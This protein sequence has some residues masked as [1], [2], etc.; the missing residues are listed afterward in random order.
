MSLS[1][2]ATGTR[3][4]ELAWLPIVGM[5][6]LAAACAPAAPPAATAVEKVAPKPTAAEKPTAAPAKPAAQQPTPAARPTEKAAE[7][8]KAAPAKPA[9]K[10]Y[11][12]GRRV[13]LIIGTTPGSSFDIRARI[14]ARHLGRYVPGSPTI[15]PQNMGGG[16]GL[17]AMNHLYN[18]AERDGTNMVMT[19]GGLY[20]RHIFGLEGIQHRLEDMIP[21]YN[22]EG[23]G[24]II[25]A[26]PTL[27]I[28]DPRDLAKVGR[29]IHYGV[30]TPDGNSVLLGI[31]GF[32]LLDVA[33]KPVMGYPGS[34]EIRL[35][36]ERGELDTGWDVSGGYTANL[37]P[38]VDAGV[39]VPLFQSGL[40][41]PSDNAIVKI[42]GLEQI[43]SF[44]ELHRAIK[45]RAPSG[46]LWDAWLLPLI[47]YGRGTVFFPP[48]VPEQAVREMRQGF[49]GM[50]KDP[51]FIADQVKLGMDPR[52][53]LNEEARLITRRSSTADPAAVEALRAIV[54]KP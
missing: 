53:Y 9:A 20:M 21:L 39:V 43:P 22:P 50:C 3:R 4:I 47:S 18:V 42:P 25:Y 34:A 54:P 14:I 5:L 41:R 35:A 12:D 6:M 40:W 32:H 51:E 16:G 48:G 13:N 2:G 27:G 49:E 23:D 38:L 8:P 26:G 7:P 10:P 15:V 36:V 1:R 52:C 24:A 29:P 17:L 45:G 31:A 19:T 11:Y 37:K 46:P 44:E 28:K 33:V 30:S